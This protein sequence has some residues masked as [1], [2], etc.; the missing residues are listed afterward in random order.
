MLWIWLSAGLLLWPMC[1]CSFFR[2]ARN[3]WTREQPQPG[4]RLLHTWL[5]L[6]VL[7]WAADWWW[8]Q[9]WLE[10]AV[11]SS[12]RTRKSW[13]RLS[14]SPGQACEE[15]GRR[16]STS[17]LVKY[18]DTGR[19][20]NPPKKKNTLYP[21]R[22]EE[23]KRDHRRGVIRLK[24]NPMPVRWVTLKSENN[25]TKEDLP[26]L[27]RFWALLPASQPGDLTEGLKIPRESDF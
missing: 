26:L 6:D 15:G 18:Y 24:S 21:K 4:T 19:G 12:R 17:S 14:R 25:N 11:G 1:M 9:W 27:W 5:K 2:S 20:W 13:Q 10:P 23:P 8:R 7:S 22:K 3:V 16:R